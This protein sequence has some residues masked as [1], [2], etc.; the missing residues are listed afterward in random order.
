MLS[1]PLGPEIPPETRGGGGS[2]GAQL[3]FQQVGGGKKPTFLSPPPGY[4]F[5]GRKTSYL[6]WFIYKTFGDKNK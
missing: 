1:R 3:D 2:A 5:V 6:V 4:F